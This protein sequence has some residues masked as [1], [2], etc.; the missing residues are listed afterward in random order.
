MRCAICVVL[1]LASALS[2]QMRGQ[3][4]ASPKSVETGPYK[5]PSPTF[6]GTLKTM[7][8]SEIVLQME[9]DQTVSIRRTRKTKFLQDGKDVKASGIALGTALEV[10]VTEGPDLKPVALKV[11]VKAA[12]PAP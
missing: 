1:V 12:P 10:D 3:R 5:I 11:V 7:D 6:R 2:G 8:N 9:G 4:K